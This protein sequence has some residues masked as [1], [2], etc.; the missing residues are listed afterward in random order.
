MRYPGYGFAAHKGY[1]TPAQAEALA[2]LDLSPVHHRSV[3]RKAHPDEPTPA[4]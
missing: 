2:E 1:G 4:E 3:D